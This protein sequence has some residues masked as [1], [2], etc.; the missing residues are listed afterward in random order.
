MFERLKRVRKEARVTCDEM[1]TLLGLQ[2]RGGYYK[3]ENGDV[4]FTL[5]EAQ[6]VARKFDMTV[7][8]IF[9]ENEVS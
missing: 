2:T 5:E 3:K 8:E 6:K 1:A 9:F 4:P 7:D